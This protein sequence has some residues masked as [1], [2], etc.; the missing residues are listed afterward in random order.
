M[1]PTPARPDYDQALKRLLLRAHDSFLA[2]VAPGLTFRGERSAE[3]PAVARRADPVWEVA[4][5]GAGGEQRG[6]LHIELQTKV[7]PDIGER[8]AEYALRLWRRDHLPVESVVVFL[9]PSASVPEP[10]FAL[11]GLGRERLVDTYTIIRL[12]EVPQERVLATPEYALWPLAGLMAGAT[13]ETTLGVAERIA[14]VPAP[15]EERREL[16]GLLVT[17]A[18]MRLSRVELLAAVRRHPMINEW[19][20]ESSVAEEFIEQGREEGRNQEARR[21]ARLVLQGR[22]TTLDAD[23]VAAI[24]RADAAT[25]EQALLHAATE[26]LEQLRSRLGADPL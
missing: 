26:T 8:I 16:T 3:L 21:M 11:P 18:G 13:V 20:R 19:L 1:D 10:R 12:W 23:L 6:L 2:L 25:L 17:L 5:S 22:F 14:A 7:E 15:L 9:R 4:R 24:E